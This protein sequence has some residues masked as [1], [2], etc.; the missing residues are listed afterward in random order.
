MYMY[1]DMYMCT[2]VH[3]DVCVYIYENVYMDMFL[4]M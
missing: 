4:H 1:M 3:A 2:Y